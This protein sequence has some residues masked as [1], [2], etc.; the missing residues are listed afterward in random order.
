MEFLAFC[1]FHFRSLHLFG[2]RGDFIIGTV[3]TELD[4]IAEQQL[5]SPNYA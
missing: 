4:V 1:H 5:D 2:D 3:E